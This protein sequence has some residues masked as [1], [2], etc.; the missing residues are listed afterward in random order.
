VAGFR[1]DKRVFS[2]PDCPG[3]FWGPSTLL[4]DGY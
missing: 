2:S 4:L 1:Q 3:R